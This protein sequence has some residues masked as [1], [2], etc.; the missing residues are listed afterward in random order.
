[1]RTNK[2]SK[3]LKS[4]NNFENL[5]R[6]RLA[7]LKS[8]LDQLRQDLVVEDE[9]DDEATQATR[10]G[11]R[12]LVILTMNREIRNISE[13]EQALERIA[14]NE[15]GVCITCEKTILKNRLQAI[16]WTRQ[17]VDCAGGA[18]NRTQQRILGRASFRSSLAS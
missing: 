5:L 12:D 1:M 9:I 11:N 17:C 6:S 8:H 13:I 16:P 3:Q 2:S 4:R 7:E 10:N 18:I 14:R 15:Y